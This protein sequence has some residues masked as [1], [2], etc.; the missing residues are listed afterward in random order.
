VRDRFLE[1]RRR[2]SMLTIRQ[3][4]ITRTFRRIRSRKVFR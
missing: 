2:L 4:T 3:L 1:E